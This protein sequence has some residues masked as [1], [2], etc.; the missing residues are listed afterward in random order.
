MKKKDKIDKEF[1][2]DLAARLP[3]GLRG[4][5][6]IQA[7]T[8][9]YSI[10][11]GHLEFVDIDVDVELLGLNVDTDD[12]EVIPLDSKYSDVIC[13]YCYTVYEFTPYLR[14]M[15]SMIKDEIEYVSNNL[16]YIADSTAPYDKEVGIYSGYASKYV[17][18]LNENHFDYNGM[19]EKG[20]AIAASEEIY[21]VK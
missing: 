15:S 6:Q 10:E 9:E 20:Y 11:S 18:W 2:K 21:K 1:L 8:G 5:V 16:L 4:I 7:S 14:L 12:I 19:I 3:Y 17:R 13:D